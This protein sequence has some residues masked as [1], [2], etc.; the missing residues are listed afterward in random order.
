MWLPDLPSVCRHHPVLQLIIGFVGH[1]IRMDDSTS[2][3]AKD[4]FALVA[5]E[6]DTAK[7]LVSSTD[8]NLEGWFA[9]L[10][11]MLWIWTCSF[12]L[13]WLWLCWPFDNRTAT[14]F[15]LLFHSRVHPQR[16]I[17]SCQMLSLIL[18]PMMRR[19]LQWL[20]CMFAGVAEFNGSR[21]TTPSPFWQ[22]I[23]LLPPHVISHVTFWALSL[24]LD[25]TLV[26]TT[27]VLLI[28]TAIPC[29]FVLVLWQNVYMAVHL[30]VDHTLV[31][32]L[33]LDPI[34]IPLSLWA[35]MKLLL[36]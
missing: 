11:A 35:P 31:E 34:T 21:C 18:L 30:A 36:I 12:I 33:I 17:W 19:H 13:W 1:F 28:E 22:P 15:P 20:E 26:L 32:S 5:I 23:W 3:L 25:E 27:R 2:L 16:L 7:P 24:L 9:C 14:I 29:H 8:V 6:I 10:L 4:R